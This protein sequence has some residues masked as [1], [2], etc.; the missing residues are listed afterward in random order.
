MARKSSAIK[1]AAFF[2]LCV[3]VYFYGSIP[4]KYEKI[5]DSD[6][7]GAVTCDK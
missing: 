7:T 4:D 1:Q 3:S 2:C 6:T 5:S